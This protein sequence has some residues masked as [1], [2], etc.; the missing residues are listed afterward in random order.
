MNVVLN[1]AQA[2]EVE[3]K[4]SILADEEDLRDGYKLTK[5]QA[6]Q[7]LGSIPMGGGSWEIP[8]W[9]VE[10]VKGEMGNHVNI[11]R[12][13]ANDMRGD[14]MKGQALA[15]NKLAAYLI[16]VFG[17]TDDDI[18]P[19]MGESSNRTLAIR[20][21]EGEALEDN[22][23][24][25]FV[26]YLKSMYSKA[27]DWIQ[28]SYQDS[29]DVYIRTLSTEEADKLLQKNKV[30]AKVGIESNWRRT[31]RGYALGDMVNLVKMGDGLG[32]MIVVNASIAE[33]AIEL[34]NKII[35]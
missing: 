19:P 28:G 13:Q 1:K 26:D 23:D 5:E 3:H 16:R 17:L 30:L 4:L 8:D 29:D 22:L 15:T 24:E 21:I 27:K 33:P 34:I 20:L 35:S 6:D 7:L 18:Y 32:W 2:E 31:L 14:G 9:G 11:L 10:A 25:G 12:D